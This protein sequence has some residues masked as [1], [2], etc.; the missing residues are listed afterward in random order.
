[1]IRVLRAMACA[2]AVTCP[3]VLG[4]CAG[5]PA[6]AVVLGVQAALAVAGSSYCTAT[7]AEAR[8]AVQARL[9]GGIAAIDCRN[10][11]HA[12]TE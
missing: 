12:G 4:G 3:L 10:T 5:V 11:G 7:T 2:V 6:A 1:M 9:T 8:R